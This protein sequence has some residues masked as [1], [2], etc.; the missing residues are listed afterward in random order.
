MIMNDKWMIKANE[1]ANCNCDYGCPCQ[2]GS[3]TTYGNCEAITSV[4]ITEGYYNDI[5]LDG[6]NFVMLYHW[7]GEIA[8]G[9]GKSQIIIDYTADED[10]REAI[11]KIAYGESTAPGT[12][13]FNVFNSTMSEVLDPLYLPIDM[14][15][16]VEAR[17]GQTTVEGLVQSKGI[18]IKN[19]FNGNDVRARI[20]LPDGFE[21]IYAEI[22]SGTSESKG[23]ISMKLDDSHGHFCVLHMNQDGVIRQP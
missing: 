3:P 4:R 8:D 17:T 16:D 5:K 12:T 6:L 11:R 14:S 15:I 13:H 23:N 2:F 20:H 1:F 21:F 18:P 10:Q 7:P 22:A 19:A 9:N